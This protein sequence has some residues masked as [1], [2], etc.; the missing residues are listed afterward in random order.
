MLRLRGYRGMLLVLNFL[1][2]SHVEVCWQAASSAD[3]S[4]HGMRGASAP[5]AQLVPKSFS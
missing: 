5:R 3:S 1:G 4:L 2:V